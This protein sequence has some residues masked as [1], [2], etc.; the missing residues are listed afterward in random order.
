MDLGWFDV[1]LN[2]Q[3]IARSLAF[4]QA[5]GFA[6]VDGGVD[7]RPSRCRRP[8]AASASTR[9]MARPVLPAVLA[10][11]CRRHLPEPVRQGPEVRPEPDRDETGVRRG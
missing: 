1:G 8:T 6:Q 4:Y 3:D 11:R 7:I 5:L 9:A 10:G 2:V